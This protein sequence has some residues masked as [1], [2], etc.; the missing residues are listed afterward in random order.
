MKPALVHV[1]VHALVLVHVLVL[2]CSRATPPPTVPSAPLEDPHGP[3]R[4]AAALAR[5][6]R[7]TVFVFFSARCPC[8]SAHDARLRELHAR[9]AP[10]GVAVYAVDSEVS[11]S[12]ERD[13]E[14]A[15]RRGYPFP[16]LVDRGARLAASLG[17]DYATYSVVVDAGGRVRFRGGIDS[18]RSHL[19]EHPATYLADALDDLLAGKEPRRAEAKALGCALTVQ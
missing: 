2:G 19:R 13:A 9:Y 6:A 16:I 12:P 10:R 17:A 14:E 7:F 3:P 4:D 11:A 5:S 1:H 15:Q 18:D 8:Q